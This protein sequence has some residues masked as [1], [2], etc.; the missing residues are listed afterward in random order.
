V[1]VRVGVVGLGEA[2]AAIA[3]GLV[4][5][6]AVVTAYDLRL[7]GAGGADL[8][9]LA[10]QAGIGLATDLADLAGQAEIILSLVTGGAALPVARALAPHLR[11][12]QLMADLNS[13]SPGLAR[14]VYQVLA[15]TGA[16]F[17]DV[18]IMAGVPPHRHRVPMLACGPGA[19]QLAAAGLGL[20]VEVIDGGPGAASAVKL[21][22]SLLVKGLESL[23]LEF[24]VA[25]D[26]F[27]ATDLVLRSM[28]GS[29]PTDDW[30]QLATYL[31]TRTAKHGRR[32]AE[33][34]A[35]V[36]ELFRELGIEPGLAEAGADRL[37]WAAQRLADQF[38]RRTPEHYQEVVDAL[39]RPG[40]EPEAER[41]C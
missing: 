5:E 28:N 3:A 9:D 8:R 6:G 4:E 13:T 18:A 40:P 19:E 41:P 25:A 39:A 14:A 11:A 36:A 17:T 16:S 24:A 27:G 15:P 31:L 32:R 29:L 37:R 12:G 34:L 1:T 7:A 20:R 23:L 35:E 2:G 26:R 30:R 33:E 38:A 22:R 21:L 10:A